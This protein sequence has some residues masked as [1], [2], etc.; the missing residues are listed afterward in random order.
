MFVSTSQDC[1]V[2]QPSKH[3][4][5]VSLSWKSLNQNYSNAP[6]KCQ[7]MSC[8]ISGNK[9]ALYQNSAT[10]IHSPCVFCCASH[11]C[12]SCYWSGTQVVQVYRPMW[13]STYFLETYLKWLHGLLFCLWLTLILSDELVDWLSLF[14]FIKMC[15]NLAISFP[16]ILVLWQ[17]HCVHFISFH[18]FHIPLILYRCGTSHVYI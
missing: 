12:H 1:M 16:C 4:S 14:T 13:W 6:T 17:L 10:F 5:E 3:P 18:L 7:E 2:S 9:N 11:C 8:F 15:L